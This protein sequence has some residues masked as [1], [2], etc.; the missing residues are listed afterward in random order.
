[1]T[2]FF[3]KIKSILPTKR[4][5]IQLYCALL[6]NANIKGFVTGNIYQ[7]PLKNACTPGL[8]CYSC[9]GASGAC[10]LGSLQN[11]FAESGKRTPYYV[12]GI[13]L[14]YAIILG[15]TIC[16]FICPFGLV[17]ELLHKI[18]TPKLKK[19]KFTKVLSYL[20][21][22]ILVFLVVI[23]PILYGLRN[24]PLPGFCKYICPA[25][26]LGGAIGLLINPSNEG[27]MGSLG[28]LFTWKFALM[29]SFIVGSIFIFRFFCRFFC[30]LGALYGLFNK[31]AI[32]GIKLEKPKCT[33][34]GLCLNKCKMDISHVGDHECINCGECLEV[35]PSNA[36]TWRGSRI[37]LPPNEI[38]E[39]RKKGEPLNDG[40]KLVLQ[41]KKK[42]AEKRNLVFKIV[43]L[44]LMA[45]LLVG[46]LVYYNVIYKEPHTTHAD[47]NGDGYCDD[48]ECN[49]YIG[50]LPDGEHYD[51]DY[52]GY[53]DDC[54]ELVAILG[55]EEGMLCYGYDLKVY[56]KNGPTGEIFNPAKNGGKITV[57][58]FWGVWCPG[59]LK[60]L[61][62]F[63][64]IASEYTDEVSVVAIHTDLLSGDEAGYIN[65][66]FP[67]SNIIFAKDEP[68]TDVNADEYYTM[69][70]GT[71]AYPIT[72]IL[73]ENGVVIAKFMHEVTYDELN[74]VITAQ[75]AK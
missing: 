74:A 60:E 59:C 26:T 15:R 3:A 66:H 71:G 54:G 14:L 56:D 32:L 28:P 20:K 50:K 48:S 43:A 27:L 53:C 73:D 24:V 16:G 36:I 69:L 38:E 29:V 22:V 21:Y 34:C 7:G 62:Y 17:Q 67:D 12:F 11:A 8:N 47:K 61:P 44:V 52:D 49:L 72:L 33:N 6:T 2:K 75:L 25:G 41:Q 30:P 68:R 57:V 39:E 70:G 10:P 23:I 5:L 9:P 65:E 45:A 40:E 35:C 55:N 4:K 42:K 19:N 1:M 37:F 18:K 58:N 64:R 51:D 63:D 46:S 31:F 13:I